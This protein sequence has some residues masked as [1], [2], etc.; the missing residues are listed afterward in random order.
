MAKCCSGIY[1]DRRGIWLPA[2]SVSADVTISLNSERQILRQTFSNEWNTSIHGAT[3]NF[4][5]GSYKGS[6]TTAAFITSFKCKIGRRTIRGLVRQNN[7][8]VAAAS[9]DGDA[10]SKQFDV[11]ETRGN[12]R[13][14]IGSIPARCRVEVEVTLVIEHVLKY[15]HRKYGLRYILPSQ[16]V[17]ES[18]ST[19]GGNKPGWMKIKVSV[20]MASPIWNMRC[21]SHDEATLSREKT[22][23]CKAYVHLSR[24]HADALAKDFVL[25]VYG[26]GIVMDESL[27]G[28]APLAVIETHPSRSDSRAILVSLVPGFQ[29]PRSN[30]TRKEIIL[31]VDTSAVMESLEP[32]LEKALK[33][34]LKSLPMGVKF[35]ICWF[36]CD[37]YGFLSYD[38]SLKYNKKSLDAAFKFAESL[39]IHYK[40]ETNVM[41]PLE[42]A[43]RRRCKE[44]E[45]EIIVLS[46]GDFGSRNMKSILELVSASCESGKS[47]RVSAVGV[48]MRRSIY[49]DQLKSLARAGT[50]DLLMVG[51]GDR[52]EAKL[53]QILKAT[54]CG[55]F[56]DCS[57]QFPGLDLETDR[58]ESQLMTK[59]SMEWRDHEVESL[60]QQ[61]IP[62]VRLANTS[63][64]EIRRQ[65][66]ALD[67][68]M[69]P[70]ML[71]TSYKHSPEL[72][73]CRMNVY[74]ILSTSE[75]LPESINVVVKSTSGEVDFTVCPKDVGVGITLHQLGAE[76]YIQELEDCDQ[77]LSRKVGI[78]AK[79]KR[80]LRSWYGERGWSV[81]SAFQVPGNWSRFVATDK[82]GKV[83]HNIHYL[84][85]LDG[86]RNADGKVRA[87]LP[88]P[89]QTI[90]DTQNST[91]DAS[92]QNDSSD[93]TPP[94]RGFSWYRLFCDLAKVGRLILCFSAGDIHREDQEANRSDPMLGYM[95]GGGWADSLEARENSQRLIELLMQKQAPDGSFPPA[96][97]EWARNITD[98]VQRMAKMKAKKNVSEVDEDAAVTLLSREVDYG[99]LVSSAAAVI[100]F[101][102]DLKDLKGVW[103]L[104]VQKTEDWGATT[105]ARNATY[106]WDVIKVEVKRRIQIAKEFEDSYWPW[107][108][109]LEQPKQRNRGA[110]HLPWS[111]M[112]V[113]HLIS[114]A[115]SSGSGTVSPC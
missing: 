106:S 91:S 39:V 4:P 11:D 7:A 9:M 93:D 28:Q 98:E 100:I 78:P 105:A 61:E 77:K 46:D 90:Q 95:S 27:T 101:Q 89:D 35:N 79:D 16:I 68:L 43:I 58:E 15:S 97:S 38:G 75:S 41:A 10:S 8:A 29:M 57:I 87:S 74:L 69:L 1:S 36:D 109:S 26:T 42:E 21:V 56:K 96:T 82:I 71:K 49:L 13:V 102:E 76:R 112:F 22:D 34:F 115:D 45:T 24:T 84:P 80:K 81:G 99:R 94:P 31:M 54:M 92:F 86:A 88:S 83:E 23:S 72:V 14:E 40:W 17:P 12:W 5:L 18:K 20:T 60:V 3:Y 65:H 6:S 66:A 55:H 111:S 114:D 52:L 103:D 63:A 59:G 104:I 2:D 113:D 85:P 64:A 62:D 67:A 70:K 48:C 108:I 73:N 19:L 53:T 44:R 110:D 25:D 33:L 47:T 32:E 51:S 107:L 30:P 37:E 50:G